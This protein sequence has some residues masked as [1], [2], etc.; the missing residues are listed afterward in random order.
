MPLRWDELDAEKAPVFYVT[1]YK[2]WSSRLRHDPWAKLASVQQGLSN[3][4][5]HASGA[6]VSD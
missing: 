3:K 4:V 1:N 2:Q 6:E 5:L